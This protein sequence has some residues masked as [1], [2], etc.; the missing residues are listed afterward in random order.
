M[1][2]K[3]IVARCRLHCVHTP[4]LEMGHSMAADESV[5]ESVGSRASLECLPVA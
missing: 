2:S 4:C 3:A 5:H 1:H